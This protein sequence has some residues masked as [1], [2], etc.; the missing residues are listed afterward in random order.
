MHTHTHFQTVY[1]PSIPD[2]AAITFMVTVN[3]INKTFTF[4]L[5]VNA[6]KYI[7]HKDFCQHIHGRNLTAKCLTHHHNHCHEDGMIFCWERGRE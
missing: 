7:Y 6:N 5:V 3:I 4:L 1:R 2:E